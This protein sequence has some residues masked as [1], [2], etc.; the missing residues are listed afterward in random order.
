MSMLTSMA[1]SYLLLVLCRFGVG[2][3]EAG[4]APAAHALITDY[5]PPDRR[6]SA[7]SVYTFGVPFGSMIG[8][9]VVGAVAQRW[10]WRPAFFVV[11]LPGILLAVVLKLVLREPIRGQSDLVS[12]PK[13]LEEPSLPPSSITEVAR[14]MFRN[15]S[16][17]HLAFGLMLKTMVGYGT[18]AFA[19]LYFIRQFGLSLSQV[20][21][22]V[23]LTTGISTGLGTLLSGFLI[24][25]AIKID[26]RWYALFPAIASTIAWPFYLAAYSSQ[27]LNNAIVFLIL[28]GLFGSSGLAPTYAVMHNLVG[29]RMRATA[30]AILLLCL[31]LIALSFGPFFTGLS[32]DIFTS[33]I[34]SQY[35]LG[36]FQEICNNG[37]LLNVSDIAK[38]C[39][40][41]SAIGTRWAIILTFM[42]GAWGSIH[43]FLGAKTLREDLSVSGL[44]G[45]A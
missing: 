41:S 21:L 32:S 16:M 36:G 24:D 38:T 13:N 29:P 23:G 44:M 10:G 39:T 11:G 20:G 40:T 4:C 3:G 43:F 17:R 33:H 25:K 2:I 5:Y 12:H 8:A 34:F 27:S 28:A 30:T 19:A 45:N 15:R 31:N 6:A 18:T 37:H 9:I 35:N 22:L 26:R 14:H 42:F 7:L 1:G